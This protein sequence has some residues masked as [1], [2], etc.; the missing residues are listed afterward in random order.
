[1]NTICNY[2]KLIIL[3]KGIMIEEGAPNEFKKKPESVA[4]AL[5][6]ESGIIM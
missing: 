3:D 1:M 2:E 5:M 4:Y 6:K